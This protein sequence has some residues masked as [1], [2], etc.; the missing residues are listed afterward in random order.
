MPA[1]SPISSQARSWL[2]R[3]TELRV[4]MNRYM[5]ST[6]LLSTGGAMLD[7]PI[8]SIIYNELYLTSDPRKDEESNSPGRD[9]RDAP[10]NTGEDTHDSTPL[11]LLMMQT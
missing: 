1:G 4:C 8:P 2:I 7:P 6:S 10:S 9:A 3:N 11:L 5:K